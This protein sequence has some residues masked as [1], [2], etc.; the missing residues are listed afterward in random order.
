M[1]MNQFD[2]KREYTLKDRLEW[3]HEEWYEFIDGVPYMMTSP[4]LSPKP[5]P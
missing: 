1:S 2:A 5:L 4:S 3:G